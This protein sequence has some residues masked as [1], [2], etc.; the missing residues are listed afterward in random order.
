MDT[1]THITMGFGLAGLAY[2]DPA[3][4]SDPSLAT[5]ILFGT[6][7]G[8]NAPDFDYIIKLVKGN[9]MYIEHHRGAS[10]SLPALIMWPLLVSCIIFFFCKNISLS[11]LLV[12]TSLAVL[13]HILFDVMNAYG[14]QAGRPFTKKWLSLNFL[15]LIDPFIYLIHLVGFFFWSIG[16]FPGTI[17]AYVYIFLILYVASRYIIS[18]KVR[19]F[20][21]KV[22]NFDG[23]YTLIPTIWIHKW[24]IVIESESTYHVG[25]FKGK[26]ILWVHQFNKHDPNCPKIKAS[27][28]DKNIVHFLANSNHTHAMI[29]PG[30]KEFEVRWMDLRFRHKNHYPYMAVAKFNNHHEIISS[31]TGWVHR[32]HKLQNKLNPSNAV[33][34]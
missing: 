20:V 6:V 23:D 29:I 11:P 12:W 24:D 22:A 26:T 1:S 7:L 15:P 32:S 17:F 4:S 3:V 8:S 27:L 31:Y 14:T 5:A 21:K 18:R 10:H 16:Y 2:L 28:N 19:S 30:N 34:L 33:Q 9:G 25:S 13:L